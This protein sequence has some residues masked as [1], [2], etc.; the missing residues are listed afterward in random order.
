M[1]INK[2]LKNI[3]TVDPKNE[4]EILEKADEVRRNQKVLC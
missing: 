2:D 3:S 1:Y 4:A